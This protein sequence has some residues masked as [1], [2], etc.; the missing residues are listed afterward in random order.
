MYQSFIIL[1]EARFP[2]VKFLSLRALIFTMGVFLLGHPDRK[3]L[4]QKKKK[5]D[6]LARENNLGIKDLTLY[7]AVRITQNPRSNIVYK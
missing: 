2:G 1:P 6:R 5:K 3:T 4:R 7:N